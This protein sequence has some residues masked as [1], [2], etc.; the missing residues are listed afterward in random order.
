MRQVSMLPVFDLLLIVVLLRVGLSR[1]ILRSPIHK[2]FVMLISVRVHLDDVLM[3]VGVSHVLS[4]V[5]GESSVCCC[6]AWGAE[7]DGVICDVH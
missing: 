6:A 4:V 3:S 1:S 2:S 5:P 7:V